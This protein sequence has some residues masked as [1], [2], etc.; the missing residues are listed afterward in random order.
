M[1]L[2]T[3]PGCDPGID[4]CHSLSGQIARM[5]SIQ[6]HPS[7]PY[8]DREGPFQHFVFV[9][10]CGGLQRRITRWQG[11]PDLPSWLRSLRA[12]ALSC[13]R[14]SPVRF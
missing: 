2:T 7:W 6:G 12:L 8:P 10:S 3:Y 13:L 1:D 9:F 5:Q 4:R 11:I 14:T